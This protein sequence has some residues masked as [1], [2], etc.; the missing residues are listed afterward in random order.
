M[1]IGGICIGHEGLQDYTL[2][3]QAVKNIESS[4][5]IHIQ[6]VLYHSRTNKNIIN[7][8]P[9]GI[10]QVFTIN[11]SENQP[12]ASIII[13][14]RNAEAVVRQ[15]IDSII[16]KTI[17]KNYEIILVDNGSDDNNALIYFK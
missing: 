17:Y 15:C 1:D 9:K 4:Q 7:E 2:A 13:P 14:T 8:Q 3:A 6:R 11:T 16:Q 12:L 10:N 5:I